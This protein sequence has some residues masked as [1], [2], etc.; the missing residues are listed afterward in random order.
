MNYTKGADLTVPGADSTDNSDVTDVAGNKTD[1]LIESV[2]TTKSLTAYLKGMIQELAQ[3]QVPKIAKNWTNGTSYSDIVNISDKGVLTGIR[4]LI[5]N[6]STGDEY[7]YIKVIIDGVTIVTNL[8]LGFYDHS[9]TFPNDGGLNFNHRFNT[10]LQVQHKLTQGNS[11]IYSSV[12][13]TTD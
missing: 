2:G 3:R 5:T 11:I 9:I 4:L 8:R 1:A 13:Y 7:C 6:P 12:T 10:S